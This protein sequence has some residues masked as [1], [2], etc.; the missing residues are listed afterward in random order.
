ML[1]KKD[2]RLSPE[3]VTG[4][5]DAEG[6]FTISVYR[7]NL[8]DTRLARVRQT[9]RVVPCFD[10]ELPI[11]DLE[12]LYLIRSF[13]N[14]SGTISVR[15][16]RKSAIYQ[17]RD[18]NSLMKEV[19]PHFNRYPLISQKQKDYKVFSMVLV[20]L[21]NNRQFSDRGIMKIVKLKSLLNWSAMTSSP[22]SERLEE[23]ELSSLHTK[24]RLDNLGEASLLRVDYDLHDITCDW[25]SG[26]IS[27][28]GCFFV[29][30]YKVKDCSTGYAVKL[31]IS[32]TQHLKDKVLMENIAR[33]LMCGSVYKH[34]KNTVVLKI[35]TFKHLMGT[36]IPL[37]EQYPIRGAKSRDFKDFCLIASKV[38]TKT[39]LRIEGLEEI[40]KIKL[41][42]NSRRS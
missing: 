13:F 2:T 26:F 9:W 38:Q 12:L 20:P 7:C 42:M 15:K 21:L 27:G 36:I 4:F 28:D 8:E 6:C 41:G 33:I 22:Q 37:L 19:I 18:L 17:I 1:S 16:S 10:I 3:W 31:S 29:N 30:I 11:R 23:E 14:E 25:L 32:I 5:T 35:S 40:R 39:H 34:S 24:H